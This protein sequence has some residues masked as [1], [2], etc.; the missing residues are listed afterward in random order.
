MRICCAASVCGTAA[1]Q[2]SDQGWPRGQ[3]PALTAS[4]SYRSWLHGGTP[5]PHAN[6]LYLQGSNPAASARVLPC[7]TRPCLT[8]RAVKMLQGIW[9]STPGSR[10]DSTCEAAPVS[11]LDL[12]IC[13]MTHSTR[14]TFPAVLFC[15]HLHTQ[16][17]CRRQ[18]S[19]VSPPPGAGLRHRWEGSATCIA[20]HARVSAAALLLGNEFFEDNCGA[21]AACDLMSS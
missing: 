10:H 20:G 4:S 11:H 21:A 9:R 7:T 14:T 6:Q 1:S 3:C 5:K 16:L 8:C 12:L 2:M 19:H 13:D 17:R 18:S 15:H